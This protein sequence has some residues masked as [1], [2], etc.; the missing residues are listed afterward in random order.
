MLPGRNGLDLCQS[1]PGAGHGTPTEVTREGIP[2]PLCARELQ[3][4]CYFIERPQTTLP[5][6][7]LLR[8][9]WG[10]EVVT[11]AR[12]VD[13]HVASLRQKL[14]KDPKQPL[15]PRCYLN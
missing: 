5:R 2:V 9:V 11:L 3:L 7:E 14:E 12:T 8:E 6:S 4:L 15:S 10:H 13:V 1:V